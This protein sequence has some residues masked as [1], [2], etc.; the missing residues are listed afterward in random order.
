MKE[1]KKIINPQIKEIMTLIDSTY[2]QYKRTRKW[3]TLQALF[4]LAF[5]LGFEYGKVEILENFKMN[6]EE[7]KKKIFKDY[8]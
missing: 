2:E 8:C 6:K 5:N 3:S 4:R 1:L 7:G